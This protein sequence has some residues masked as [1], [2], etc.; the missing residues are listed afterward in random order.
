MFRCH[1]CK[2]WLSSIE[3]DI[4]ISHNGKTIEIKNIP[5]LH[6]SFCDSIIIGQSVKERA[7][8]FVNV[9]LKGNVIDYT[10]C[11]AAE[12]VSLTTLLL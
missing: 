2:K 9:Y 1:K 4:E 8:Q 6:C 12:I 10:E 7:K 5:A 3:T 11:E